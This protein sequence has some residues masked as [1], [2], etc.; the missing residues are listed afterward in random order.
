MDDPNTLRTPK[1]KGSS[2]PRRYRVTVRGDVPVNLVD[3]VSS[4]HAS[5]L[6]YTP[7]HTVALGATNKLRPDSAKQGDA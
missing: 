4:A 6:A 3:I 2:S 7:A 5:A 1:S